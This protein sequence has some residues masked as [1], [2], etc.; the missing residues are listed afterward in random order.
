MKNFY[1]IYLDDEFIGQT[2]ARSE[3]E[4]KK[5]IWWKRFKNGDKYI[6]SAYDSS[7]LEALQIR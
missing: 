1:Y 2:W 4:A 7:D 3:E 5:N 6:T